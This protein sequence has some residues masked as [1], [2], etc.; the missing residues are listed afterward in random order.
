MSKQRSSARPQLRGACIA[1]AIALLPLLGAPAQAQT[2]P[3]VG[4]GGR[5]AETGAFTAGALRAFN[6]LVTRWSAAWRSGDAAKTAELYSV[7][8]AVALRPDELVRGRD[9]VRQYLEARIP[10][11]SDLRIS[12]TDFVSDGELIS[13]TGPFVLQGADQSVTTGTYSMTLRLERGGW[14]IR[15]QLFSPALP[16]L[17]QDPARPTQ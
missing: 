6:E 5:E 7:G 15:S 14:H 16:I 13:A 10:P 12:A 3:G 17:E 9:G 1:T 8:A 2:V 4:G 11:G